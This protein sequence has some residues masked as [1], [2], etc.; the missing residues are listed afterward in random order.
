MDTDS[1]APLKVTINGQDYDVTEA[2]EFIDKG[3]KTKELEEKYNTKLDNVW[4]E[5][6]QK[7]QVLKE[8][9]RELEEA[10]KQ[11]AEFQSKQTR[12]IETPQDVTQARE[13]AKK[14]GIVLDDDLSKSGYVKQDDLDKWYEGRKTQEQQSAQVL[15]QAGK[16][17]TEIDGSDGRPRFKKNV[18][19]SYMAQ[20][21]KTDMKEAYEEIYADELKP[22][23]DAQ[24]KAQ[25]AKALKTMS[26]GG[27]KNPTDPK[28][29]D[30]NLKE[31]LKEALS[32]GQE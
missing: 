23:K 16:L 13:A 31:M 28:V 18:V 19:L 5:Y 1:Q 22:W 3:K 10:R 27:V 14:L 26:G 4:P 30:S 17:E 7:S 12:E 15:D 6:N 2:Q 8:R 29:N 25:Q 32:G 11:L 21:G 9:E 20:F 24:I